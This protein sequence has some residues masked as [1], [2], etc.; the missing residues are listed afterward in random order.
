MGVTFDVADKPKI[1]F[2]EWV[3]A[4]R[5]GISE[6]YQRLLQPMLAGRRKEQM[7]QRAVLSAMEQVYS[8]ALALLERHGYEYA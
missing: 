8:E 3:G 7:T 2:S 4:Q 1:R 6:R 5:C